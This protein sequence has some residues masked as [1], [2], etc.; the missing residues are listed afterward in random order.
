MI[1]SGSHCF[2]ACNREW[3]SD[4]VLSTALTGLC[5]G[6]LIIIIIII[7]NAWDGCAIIVYLLTLQQC[8][9]NMKP[10]VTAEEKWCVHGNRLYIVDWTLFSRRRQPYAQ[11]LHMA[12]AGA[13]HDAWRDIYGSACTRATQTSSSMECV[14]S[15][16][17][18]AQTQLTRSIC[19]LVEPRKPG[20]YLDYWPNSPAALQHWLRRMIIMP[21]HEADLNVGRKKHRQNG[22]STTLSTNNKAMCTRCTALLRHVAQK[23]HPYKR[24]VD[25]DLANDD[26]T[27]ECLE[28]S[29]GSEILH[30]ERQIDLRLSVTTQL[31][32]IFT[33]Y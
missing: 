10:A 19:E 17:N 28:T 1:D 22:R 9:F 32:Y 23:N 8:F 15:S 18:S 5:H 26:N 24:Y 11:P 12:A 20:Q 30:T 29:E 21:V 2:A 6:R 14:F 3:I 16:R 4:A 27:D 25:V 31:L 7:Y 33:Y 13:I